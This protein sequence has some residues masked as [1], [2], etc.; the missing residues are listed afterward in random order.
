MMGDPGN[1]MTLHL[2]RA[3]APDIRVNAVCPW[4]ITTRG[5]RKASGSK[6]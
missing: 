4:L 5:S 3:L 2:A 6:A 1:A